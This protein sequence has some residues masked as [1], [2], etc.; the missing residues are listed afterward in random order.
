MEPAEAHLT[1]AL[2]SA[3]RA[4]LRHAEKGPDVDP[5]DDERREDPEQERGLAD[6]KP[7]K[8][9]AADLV[10]RQTMKRPSS[11][12]SSP[13]ARTSA[14]LAPVESDELSGVFER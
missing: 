8:L 4:A 5:D 6:R 9:R 3:G 7:G 13:H 10:S 1:P 14:I 11:L 2:S 12:S